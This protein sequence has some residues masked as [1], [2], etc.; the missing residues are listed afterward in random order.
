MVDTS[1]VFQAETLLPTKFGSFRFRI[2]KNKKDEEVM[3]IIADRASGL[4]NN[5]AVRIHSACFTAEA[6]G[7]LKC[8]CKEQL[9]YALAYIAEHGGAVIYLAQEGRGIGL[10]NKIRAYAIQEKGHDTIEANRLLGLPVDCREY[11]EAAFIL[12]DIGI[13]SLRMITNNPQKIA[14]MKALGFPVNGRIPVLATGNPHSHSYLETKRQQMG[15]MLDTSEST[16][17]EFKKGTGNDKNRPF[18]HVNF[19]ISSSGD[20]D[21]SDD[22]VSNI[23]CYRDWQR[24]HELRE[25]YA[26]VVVGARTWVKDNPRLTVRHDRLGRQPLR[27]PDRVIFAG[28]TPCMVSPSQQRNFVV[29]LDE[30]VA[31]NSIHI[32]AD[33]RDLCAP[34]KSLLN[35]NVDTLLVEGGRTLLNSFIHQKVVD[36]FTVYVATKC[37]EEAVNAVASSF[38]ELANAEMGIDPLGEGTLLSYDYGEDQ[39]YDD[40]RLWS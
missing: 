13:S 4:E 15:H 23:S 18:V 25:K 22:Q 7:S 6:I 29:G 1:L 2:Y 8:D 24:V 32:A 5:V 37:G 36:R 17:V 10:S 21:L 38:P 31:Q 35:H 34:L 20:M 26:A 19:A 3:A 12:K 28:R 16:V 27:Q 30:A 11:D 9:D 40:V 33:D 39:V 14:A